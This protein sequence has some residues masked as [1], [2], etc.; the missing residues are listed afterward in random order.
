MLSVNCGGCFNCINLLVHVRG[1]AELVDSH[2][3]LL[4]VVL[5]EQ[6]RLA[7]HHLLNGSRNHQ[8][9]DVIICF[10]RFP[11]FRWNNLQE[12]DRTAEEKVVQ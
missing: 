3:L 5:C 11:A 1:L 12:K 9:V 6:S 2:W 10:P 7:G 4:D 8:V